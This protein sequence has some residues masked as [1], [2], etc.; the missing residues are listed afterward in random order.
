MSPYHDWGP[1]LFD[2]AMLAKKLKVPPPI[3][4]LSAVAGASGRMKTVSATGGRDTQ[5]TVTGAQFRA[6][7][8]LRSTWFSGALFALQPPA[9]TITYGGAVSLTGFARGADALSLE[10]KT[11]GKDWSPAG[12]VLLD[13]DGAFSTIVKPTVGTQ[14]RLVWTSVRAGLAKIGV[15]PKVDAEVSAA[16]VHGTERPIVSGAAV[17]LQ[18]QTGTA[19]TTVSS[20]SADATG[21][22]TFASGQQA[23]TYRVRCAPAHGLAPG[24]SA[25]L[26]IE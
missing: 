24:L 4:S 1:V 13:M 20:T 16:G 9:K 25:P 15:A 11:P 23:G 26:L 5:A 7:L 2:G 22:F 18:Q 8:G 6:L 21:S 17:Q 14:Y 12:D 10:S 19:W 3:A